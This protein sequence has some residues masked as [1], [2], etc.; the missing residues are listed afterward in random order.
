MQIKIYLIM[1][2]INFKKYIG[3]T[4]RTVARRFYEHSLTNSP[5]LKAGDS[6]IFNTC[7]KI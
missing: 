5:R 4:S 3:L 6:A 1:N 7:L 2:R